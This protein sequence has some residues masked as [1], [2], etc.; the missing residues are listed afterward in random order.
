[1]S[2]YM[3]VRAY[4]VYVIGKSGARDLILDNETDIERVRNI[5]LGTCRKGKRKVE[6]ECNGKV[7]VGGAHALDDQ[8]YDRWLAIAAGLAIHDRTC[9]CSR[10]PVS[11]AEFLHKHF[12]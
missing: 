11:L 6:I 10:L 7:L 8:A 2:S 3:L 9:E 5:A 1:M 12:L 4:S